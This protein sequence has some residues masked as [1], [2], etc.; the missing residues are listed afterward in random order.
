MIL[1]K[2]LLFAQGFFIH[3]LSCSLRMLGSKPVLVARDLNPM[4]SH[5]GLI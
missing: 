3:E 1:S 2:P 4:C 5:V